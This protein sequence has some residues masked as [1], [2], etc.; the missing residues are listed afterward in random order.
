MFV[1]LSMKIL[2]LLIFIWSSKWT[3]SWYLW[4]F[5][6]FFTLTTC[7]KGVFSLSHQKLQKDGQVARSERHQE[8]TQ[9]AV[10]DLHTGPALAAVLA[11]LLKCPDDLS[12][13][14]NHHQCR[15]KESKHLHADDDRRL[16]AFIWKLVEAGKVFWIR[17]PFQLEHNWKDC[18]KH[19]RP[20]GQTGH[21]SRSGGTQHLCFKRVTDSHPSIYSYAHNDVYAS[22]DPI[23]IKPFQNRTQSLVLGIPLVITGVH[24]E[25]KREEEEQVHQSQV[26]HVDRG[27]SLFAQKAAEHYQRCNVEN[28]TQDKYRYVEDQLQNLHQFIRRIRTVTHVGRHVGTAKIIVGF[29]FNTSGRIS[30]KNLKLP[31]LFCYS[32]PHRNACMKRHQKPLSCGCRNCEL[33][34]LFL[35]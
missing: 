3:L 13:T 17:L 31:F 25:R 5:L 29:Y 4:T 7:V 19:Q 11:R 16:P 23:K 33:V 34:F 27:F 12:W 2:I 35:V 21:H 32:F 28:Q 15:Q 8:R 14:A 9:A 30:N 26:Y 24:F 10:D 1:W 20:H 6:S 22:I 18:C